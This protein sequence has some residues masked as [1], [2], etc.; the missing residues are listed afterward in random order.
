MPATHQLICLVLCFFAHTVLAGQESS[1]ASCI[2]HNLT[3]EQV[4]A[5]LF[6]RSLAAFAPGGV[7]AIE[8]SPC[9]SDDGVATQIVLSLPKGWSSLNVAYRMRF[10]CW[11]DP[12]T[13]MLTKSKNNYI[14]QIVAAKIKK[15]LSVVEREETVRSFVE[16]YQPMVVWID[17]DNGADKL[18]LDF[19]SKGA[20][21]DNGPQLLLQA[22]LPGFV[23][24][25]R[26]L[27][28]D[29]LPVRRELLRFA[30]LVSVQQPG[31]SI[32]DIKA[33]RQE[34]SVDENPKKILW[35][36]NAK[37]HGEGCQSPISLTIDENGNKAPDPEN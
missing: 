36:I 21:N 8:I 30:E 5:R 28:I 12:G 6:V 14:I 31:C 33:Q 18:R 13:G 7:D 37:L 32:R 15:L 16:R 27:H 1:A 25:Y 19:Q 9:L 3:A 4:K 23:V 24:G 26:L 11:L 35:T 22:N 17:L 2:A 20:N 29:G 10:S 34:S